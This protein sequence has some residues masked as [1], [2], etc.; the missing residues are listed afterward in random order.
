MLSVKKPGKQIVIDISEEDYEAAAEIVLACY[1]DI[2]GEVVARS[3]AESESMLHV[4][5]LLKAL[6]L[7]L[8]SPHFRVEFGFAAACRL[9]VEAVRKINSLMEERPILRQE[10][11]KQGI[12]WPGLENK[13]S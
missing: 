9:L 2:R 10:L 5:I 8:A 1:P 11:L 7:M 12:A 4:V 6:Q 13:N 3:L